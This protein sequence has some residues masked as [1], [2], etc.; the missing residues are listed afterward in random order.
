[1][2]CKLERLVGFRLLKAV[3]SNQSRN[4]TI[5][6][7]ICYHPDNRGTLGFGGGKCVKSKC[8]VWGAIE[9]ANGALTG[10]GNAVPSN[11]VVGHSESKKGA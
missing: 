1:M 2:N 5:C 3:C 4:P 7:T 11:G 8:P 9:K 10:G 6:Y